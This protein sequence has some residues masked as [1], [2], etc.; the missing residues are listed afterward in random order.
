MVRNVKQQQGIP[1]SKNKFGFSSLFGYRVK[2]DLHCSKFKYC[3]R[4]GM[5]EFPA[6]LVYFNLSRAL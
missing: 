3:L 4:A 2:I 5:G 1:V 6:R